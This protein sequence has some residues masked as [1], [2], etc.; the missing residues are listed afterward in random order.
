MRTQHGYTVVTKKLIDSL[1][2]VRYAVEI[3]T[4]YVFTIA[5]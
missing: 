1:G 2:K 4:L 5:M 3:A